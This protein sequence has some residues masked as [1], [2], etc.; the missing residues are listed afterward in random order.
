L[1]LLLTQEKKNSFAKL[2]SLENSHVLAVKG[3]DEALFKL[4]QDV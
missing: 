2:T 3:K 1:A 4:G